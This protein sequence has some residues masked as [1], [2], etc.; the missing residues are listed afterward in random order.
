MFMSNRSPDNTF[1]TGQRYTAT[2]ICNSDCTWTFTIV[3]RTAKTVWFTTD[4]GVGAEAE[5]QRRAIKTDANI[6]TIADRNIS[7]YFMPFG[8]YSMA[9]SCGADSRVA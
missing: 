9:A 6:W 3:K 7:E 5:V 2:S 8:T 4:Y 1:E